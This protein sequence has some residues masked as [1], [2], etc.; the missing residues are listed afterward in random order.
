MPR[1]TKSFAAWA[2]G[3]GVLAEPQA[4]WVRRLW[5]SIQSGVTSTWMTGR[6]IWYKKGWNALQLHGQIS[7]ITNSAH[8]YVVRIMKQCRC[9]ALQNPCNLKASITTR[10]L[11]LHKSRPPPAAQPSP[12][13]SS[14]SQASGSSQFSR[15]NPICQIALNL[16]LLFDTL[17]LILSPFLTMILFQPSAEARSKAVELRGR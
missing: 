4:S 8:N 16:M 10:Q 13:R 12:S 11:A 7:L 17:S 2:D 15:G 9:P 14:F 5:E 1:A 3:R 6:V